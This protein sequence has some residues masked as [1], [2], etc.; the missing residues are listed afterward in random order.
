MAKYEV[1]QE[2]YEAIVGTNPAEFKGA[3]HPV[4]NMSWDDAQEFIGKLNEKFKNQKVRFRLP[5]EAE[6]EY[7]CRAGTTAYNS[8]N[9]L[10]TQEAPSSSR[11]QSGTKPVGSFPPNS[12]GLYD[13]HGNVFEWC[14]DYFGPYS[15]ASNDGTA[16]LTRQS[17]ASEV[18]VIRGGDWNGDV[19][20]CRSAF[21]ILYAPW[22][23]NP[24][25]GFRVVVV[26]Q[27]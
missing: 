24:F 19:R 7:S 18:R 16:Q 15:K 8:R 23:R 12:F 3:R 4:G 26:S 2:Q 27:E 6:W 20:I 22:L 13:L 9:T 21:S 5:S 11:N 17:L 14:D 25:F 1:T 10:P